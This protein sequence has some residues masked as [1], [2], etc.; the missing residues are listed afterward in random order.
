MLR[1]PISGWHVVLRDP[2]GT[3]DI[4]LLEAPVLDTRLALSLLARVAGLTGEGCD[5]EA[6]PAS[7]LEVMLLWLRRIVLGDRIRADAVCIDPGCRKRVEISFR[8]GDYLAH[9]V[10]RRVRQV[11][12][13]GA[14][15]RFRDA[16]AT[17]RLPSV[18]DKSA[19]R[20]LPDPA[21]E[22]ARRCID[23]ADLPAQQERRLLQ[24]MEAM[25][26]TIS[27]PLEGRCP[28]C[29]GTVHVYFDVQLFVLTELRQQAVFVYRD[30]HL[31]ASHYHWPEQAILEL[32]K[33]RRLSYVD[34]LLDEG[35]P[36]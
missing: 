16:A 21:R 15:F 33:S 18:A 9:R 10:P 27:G 4:L 25:A 11:E 34:Q 20:G 32:P 17:F 24:A 14:R 19:V 5:W 30:V 36:A 6:L 28:E 23:C 8:I 12:R 22:I 31:L 7:D 26:P 35:S 1:L 13:E 29:S 2:A 3:E